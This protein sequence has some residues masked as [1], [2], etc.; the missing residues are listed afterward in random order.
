MKIIKHFEEIEAKSFS[1]DQVRGV[2]GRVAIG[3]ADGA[4]NFCMRL[5]TVEP[6]GHTPRHSHDWEHEILV[7]EGNGQVFR[8]GSWND[9]ERGSVIFI[10]PNEEHQLRN[11][12]TTPFVFACLIPQGA[13]EL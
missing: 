4:A 10:P 7:H 6:G 2:A 11:N 5:F 1:G 12:D 13:P 9:I 8:D 3:A